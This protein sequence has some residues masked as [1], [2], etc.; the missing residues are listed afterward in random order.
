MRGFLTVVGLICMALCAV[1]A[2][3]SPFL[4]LPP[5]WRQMG[6]GFALVGAQMAIWLGPAM[7]SRLNRIRKESAEKTMNAST[8]THAPDDARR[9]AARPVT[10][11]PS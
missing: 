10:G 4:R 5:F 9:V 1:L 3:A 11:R 2:L 6:V 8:Q 7:A